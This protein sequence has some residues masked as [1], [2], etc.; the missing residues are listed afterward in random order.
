M[1]PEEALHCVEFARDKFGKMFTLRPKACL[2]IIEDKQYNCP[3]DQP[4]ELKNLRETIKMLERRPK[5]FS[6][7]IEYAIRKFYKY[8]R[9]DIK[10]LIYTYP[11]D[12]KVKSG[13]PFWKLPKRPPQPIEMFDS[14]NL[15]HASFITALAVLR[16]K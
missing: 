3:L 16:A 14:T 7:C 1:F 4:G 15:L 11:L 8:F 12:M 9:N 6:Q 13:E 10:Q 5:D 2:K